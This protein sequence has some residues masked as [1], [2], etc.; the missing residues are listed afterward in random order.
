MLQKRE[1]EPEYRRYGITWF[2]KSFVRTRKVFLKQDEIKACKLASL[3][4]HNGP[5]TFIY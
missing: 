3:V 5:L 1:R 4:L 2:P